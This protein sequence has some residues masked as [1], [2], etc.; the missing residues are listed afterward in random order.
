MRLKL[1]STRKG[2]LSAVLAVVIAGGAATVAA[3][4]LL[5]SKAPTPIPRQFAIPPH[6]WSSL[7]D[8]TAA[9][10][11]QYCE[12]R[13]KF[14]E[15]HTPAQTVAEAKAK[16][17]SV[18]AGLKRQEAR[19][20][21][22]P[23][24]A[25]QLGLFGGVQQGPFP[26]QFFHSTGYW[27]GQVGTQYY[28]VY[29]GNILNPDTGVATQATVLVYANGTNEEDPTTRD[30][31]YQIPVGTTLPTIAKT[32]GS[33]LLI[34]TS[35]GKKLT[36][37]T[38]SR[39]ISFGDTPQI[40]AP[41]LVLNL[42]PGASLSLDTASATLTAG[43]PAAPLA[44]EKLTFTAGTTTLCSAT[45]D[46]QGVATCKYNLTGLVASAL[47]PLGYTVTFGGDDSFTEFAG[48]ADGL[49]QPTSAHGSFVTVGGLG[50]ASRRSRH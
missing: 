46:A 44:G 16:Q 29:A 50:L 10:G 5:T 11:L 13:Q 28:H 39:Q 21:P 35:Q 40:A 24:P 36:F 9:Q 2:V 43:S 12:R 38:P 34:Q 41:A 30:G 1:P 6:D 14:L 37:D 18:V 32:H 4:A 49:Y 23:F 8:C 15:T 27:F 22:T 17:R 20:K 26:G 3:A 7:P 48:N 47:A 42:V 31:S 33:L 19:A 45:T 25:S